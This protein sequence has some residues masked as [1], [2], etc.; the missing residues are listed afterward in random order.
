MIVFYSSFRSIAEQTKFNSVLFTVEI[1]A[2]IGQNTVF[3]GF[4]LDLFTKCIV[5]FD[6]LPRSFFIRV[7][8]EFLL[9][10]LRLIWVIYD[11][12]SQFLVAPIVVNLSLQNDALLVLNLTRDMTI[13]FGTL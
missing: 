3:V 4:G 13:S 7:I 2:L 5:V 6:L 12:I 11:L 10:Y 9:D 1:S 8:L